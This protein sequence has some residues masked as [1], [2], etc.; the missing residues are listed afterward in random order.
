MKM[1][2]TVNCK[3]CKSNV[4][5]CIFKK[6]TIKL[7]RYVEL[8]QLKVYESQKLDLF[9]TDTNEMVADNTPRL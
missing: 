6:M 1:S 4:S 7:N 5:F 3:F 9:D 8:V 2:A